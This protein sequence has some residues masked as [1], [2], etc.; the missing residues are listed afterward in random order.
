VPLA[1]VQRVVGRRGALGAVR[2]M[3]NWQSVRKQHVVWGRGDWWGLVG[4]GL[5]VEFVIDKWLSGES[6][7]K[8]RQDQRFKNE[9]KN[10]Q[11]DW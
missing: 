3:G 11:D 8:K 6:F 4:G 7:H 9:N 1:G 10:V 2:A 5:G